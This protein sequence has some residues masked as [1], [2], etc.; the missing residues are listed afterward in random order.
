[1]LWPVCLNYHGFTGSGGPAD[2]P[3]ACE[4]EPEVTTKVTVRLDK[5]QIK[6][7][8]EG[9]PDEPYLWVVFFKVDGTT[10]K[11]SDLPHATATLHAAAGSHEN[12]GDVDDLDLE[13]GDSVAIPPSIGRWDTTLQPIAGLSAATNDSAVQIGVVVLA[14]EEDATGDSAADKGRAALVATLQKELDK[15][16]QSLSPP[17]FEKTA[18]KV[19]DAVH[20]AIADA[21]V[22]VLSFMPISSL[23]DIVGIVDPDDYVGSGVAG[24]FSAKQLRDAGGPGLPI[25]LPLTGEGEGEYVVTGRALRRPGPIVAGISRGGAWGNRLTR[26]RSAQTFVAETQEL[27]DKKG[28]RLDAS[29]LGVRDR[30]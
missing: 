12:L 29:T 6:Q 16:V 1:V 27:F 19:H 25:S 10:V 15:A 14:V 21:S 30:R 26:G 13:A 22:S 24:P 8:N 20:D 18:D 4:K 11:L 23:L 3:D 5:L 28:L 17:D 7:Q 2:T 9:S